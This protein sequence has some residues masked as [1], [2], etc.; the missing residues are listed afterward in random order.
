ME[1]ATT[2]SVCG[3]VFS[4]ASNLRKH[5][6]KFHSGKLIYIKSF[7]T[8]SVLS[9]SFLICWCRLYTQIHNQYSEYKNILDK[10]NVKQEIEVMVKDNLYFV[11]HQQQTVKLNLQHGVP[12][13]TRRHGNFAGVHTLLRIIL[14]SNSAVLIN[15]ITGVSP[16]HFDFFVFYV[17]CQC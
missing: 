4:N 11:K 13:S 1:P 3:V 16:P 12:T 15:I 5:T 6:R 10:K 14:S 7:S 2:C 9:V 17:L 8:T